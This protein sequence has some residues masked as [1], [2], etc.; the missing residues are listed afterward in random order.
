MTPVDADNTRYFWFQHRNSD[1]D[2]G[3]IS[4]QMFEGAKQAFI[5]GRDVLTE[6]HRGMKTSRT[7]HINLG[8]DAGA[9][10]FRKM[11][12]R[13]IEASPSPDSA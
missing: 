5:E 2:N 4:Q 12:E 7:R 6:V 3:A 8:L 13:R 10:R 9:M 1:P 11:V